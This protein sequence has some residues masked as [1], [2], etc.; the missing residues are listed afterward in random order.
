MGCTPFRLADGTAGFICTRTPR[1]RCA[2]GEPATIQCDEPTGRRK[3]TCS[4]HLCAACAVEIE[5]EVHLCPAH[6]ARRAAA[7]AGSELF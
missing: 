4:R 1:P 3:G 5:P 7:D 2:C 6:A